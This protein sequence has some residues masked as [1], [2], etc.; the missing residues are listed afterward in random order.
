[1]MKKAIKYAYIYKHK[2]NITNIK[3]LRIYAKTCMIQYIKCNTEI[4]YNILI[5]LVLTWAFPLC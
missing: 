2:S 1:M 4:R 3:R 5:R